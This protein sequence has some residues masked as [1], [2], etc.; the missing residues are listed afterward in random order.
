MTQSVTILF[1]DSGT[2]LH[3]AW[4]FLVGR[5]S[6]SDGIRNTPEPIGLDTACYSLNLMPMMFLIWM[7]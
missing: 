3:A 2:V 7:R 4:R 5:P 6:H 1:T